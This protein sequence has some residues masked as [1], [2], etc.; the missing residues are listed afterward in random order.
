MLDKIVR[1]NLVELQKSVLSEVPHVFVTD[2]KLRGNH[3]LSWIRFRLRVH[4]TRHPISAM[5]K[6]V[7][8]IKMTSD[9]LFRMANQRTETPQVDFPNLDISMSLTIGSPL[10]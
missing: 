6:R 2:G 10:K 4:R 1:K 7:K 9:R 5:R 8:A 3:I